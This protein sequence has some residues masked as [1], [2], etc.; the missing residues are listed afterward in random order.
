MEQEKP[1]VSY[2]QFIE[3][4]REKQNGCKPGSVAW[5]I[6]RY[7][8][9]MATIKPLGASHIYTLRALA[10]RFLGEKMAKKLH[11]NDIKEYAKMRRQQFVR[12]T[13]RLV[14]P[15]TIG[16]EVSYLRGVLKYAASEWDDCEGVSAAPI[17]DAEP[18]LRKHNLTGKSTPRDRRPTQAELD[19][20]VELAVERN[21]NPRTEIDLVKITRWQVA[22]GRRISETCRI[23]WLGWNEADQTMLVT[24][25]KDPRTRN[26]D[27]VV[28]LTDDA[29]LML[30]EIAWEMNAAGPDAWYDQQQR[31][32]PYNAKCA[33]QA[34]ADLKEKAGIKGLRLHDSRRECGSRLVES[35]RTSPE[36]ILVT[37][38]DSTAIF[39][40][41]YMRLRPENFKHGP[42]SQQR[43]AV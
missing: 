7:I 36:A 15:A 31:I 11:K 6:E 19:H 33:S 37:G 4:E 5:L 42:I 29:Q 3:Q 12:N 35:G 23:A 40:K 10:R 2:A 24:K 25:M 41:N 13:Q 28:A 21:R 16:Q 32:F 1:R 26:K 18:S 17:I 20:L 34:Y 30:Y 39:E 22:S 9:E 8:T 38:H 14:N 27:K 43:K